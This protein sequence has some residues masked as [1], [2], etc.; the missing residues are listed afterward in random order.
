MKSKVVCYG[1]AVLRGIISAIILGLGI[2]NNNFLI[3][4]CG[5]IMGLGSV[6]DAV[7][8]YEMFEIFEE[9]EELTEKNE[10]LEYDL[11]WWKNRF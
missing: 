8:T 11:C 5:V 3:K 7:I 2:K 4:I 6:R 9:N 10:K 1:H